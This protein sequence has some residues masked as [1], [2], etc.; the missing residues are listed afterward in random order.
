MGTWLLLYPREFN[1]SSDGDDRSILLVKVYQEHHTRKN[2]LVGILTDTIGGV[3]GRLKD[4]GTETFVMICSTDAIYPIIV[5]EETLRKD[6]SDGSDLSG[7]T[8]KFALVAEPRGDVNADQR[9][10]IDAVTRATEAVGA[11]GPTPAV[12]DHLSS[13]V[14]TGANAVAE[15]Q[16]F[17]NTWGV[18]LQRMEL[19]NK[20]VAEIAQVYDA[21]SRLHHD[22]NAGQIHPYTSLAWS[23]ISAANQVCLLLCIHTIA[24]RWRYFTQVLVNQKNRDTQIIGLAGTM[25]D[26]FAFVHDAEPLKAIQAHIKPITLL[27]QQVT[28]CGYFITE[29]TKQK[30]FCQLSSPS[31]YPSL[32]SISRDPDDEIHD[33]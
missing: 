26:V 30:S 28:E 14:D 16:T 18:L 15:V 20:I 24:D 17:E 31:Q 25:S 9:Q 4:G 13:V 6:A 10:A 12:V 1:V 23:V 32:I 11:L 29:Y 5:L 2:K 3:L 22:L 33:L 19:F 8:I 21:V 7:M 27:I